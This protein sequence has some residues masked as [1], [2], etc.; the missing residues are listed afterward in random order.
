MQQARNASMWLAEEGVTP[1]FLIRDGDR[2]FPD[3]FKD[4]W[5]AEEVR[6]I[7]IPPRA[8]KAN[9][10]SE[11]WVGGLK[12]ECLNFFMCFS[13][14]QLHYI[15]QTWVRHYNTQR[16]NRGI[17]INNNVLDEQFKPQCAGPVLCRQK[18]GGLIKEYYREAA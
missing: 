10:F 15:T 7:R 1:R 16:P 6:V 9:A 13:L 11:N 5:K 17:G 4:F 8:P 18:L 2:K 3:K 14:D 12:R